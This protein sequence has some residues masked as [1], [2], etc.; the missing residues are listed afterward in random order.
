ME[1]KNKI[2]DHKLGEDANITLDVG[3]E[4]VERLYYNNV[5]FVTIGSDCVMMTL[6]LRNETSLRNDIVNV[7][8]NKEQAKGLIK[9]LKQQIKRLGR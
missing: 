7:S 6:S 3:S 9:G 4:H 8:M 2:S 1:I 5:P